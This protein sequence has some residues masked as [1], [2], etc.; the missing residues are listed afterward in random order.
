MLNK[1]FNIYSSFKLASF[2][3]W[4]VTLKV[5]TRVQKISDRISADVGKKNI[6]YRIGTKKPHR[7]TSTKG[8]E[9]WIPS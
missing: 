6:G 1:K 4:A 2:D 5:K 9:K 7:L 8:P 3:C